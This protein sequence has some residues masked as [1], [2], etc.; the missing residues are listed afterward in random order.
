MVFFVGGVTMLEIAALRY[1]ANKV[2]DWKRAHAQEQYPYDILIV[3]TNVTNGNKILGE[4]KGEAPLKLPAVKP[5][6]EVY[7]TML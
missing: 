6:A 4:L 2:R 5:D 1:L 7:S 3:T